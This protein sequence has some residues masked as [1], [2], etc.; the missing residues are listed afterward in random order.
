[1][2]I[3]YYRGAVGGLL[4]Y[5]VTDKASFEHLEKW[6]E[7]LTGH[8][9]PGILVMLVGNKSDLQS[10]RQVSTQ[11]G[12]DFAAKNGLSFIETSAKTGAQVDSAFAKIIQ[13][14]YKAQ[15]AKLQVKKGDPVPEPA[16]PKEGNVIKLKPEDEPAEGTDG[17][18]PAPRRGCC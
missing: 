10:A 5:S 16:K 11:E 18:K 13:E 14:I 3:S 2:V 9:E 15:T 8:A 12:K 1:M 7:E 4:V 17:S 6:L